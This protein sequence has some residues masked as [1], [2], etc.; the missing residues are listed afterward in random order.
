MVSYH[1]RRRGRGLGWWVA[2]VIVFA[3]GGSYWVLFRETPKKNDKLAS[4]DQLPLTSDRPEFGS[5]SGSD[6]DYIERGDDNTSTDDNPTSHSAQPDSSVRARQLLSAGRRSLVDK[7]FVT[8][9][10]QLSEA[11]ELGVEKR[12]ELQLRAELTLISEETI[13]SPRTMENDPLVQRYIVKSGDNLGAIAK[14]YDVSPEF[15]G[16]I[17]HLKNI[18]TIRVGQ[19]LKAVKGP[20][21][22]VISKSEYTLDVYL[23]KGSERTF[24]KRF[25]VGLGTDGS[26][27]LGKW[28]VKNKL[29]DP[30]YYPPRGGKIIEAGDPQNP[31]G[32]RWIGLEG[33][34]GEALGQLRY[35]IHGTIEPDSIG[36]NA[37]MGC[38]RL[39][40]T[41]VE[42]LFDYLVIDDSTVLI[43][44]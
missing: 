15:L 10:E 42:Y 33:I 6:L 5:K 1:R 32:E 38:V 17:N 16:R 20:F 34:S 27:P 8:A 30:T 37:S 2:G 36:K 26:T 21:H 18:N 22:A 19:T 24:V 39:Y 23:G 11:L 28:K 7:D 44:P 29:K 25:K 35:G 12:E 41:D 13:F 3:A 43:E 4:A 31:L 14:S 9:R 40:N